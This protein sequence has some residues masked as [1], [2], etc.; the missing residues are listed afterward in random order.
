M[1]NAFGFFDLKKV[2]K[3]LKFVVGHEIKLEE[4]TPVENHLIAGIVLIISVNQQCFKT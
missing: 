1:N 3:L 4:I 2:E